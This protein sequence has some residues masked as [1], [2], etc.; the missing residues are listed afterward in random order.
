MP[1]FLIPFISSIRMP[2]SILNLTFPRGRETGLRRIL[3]SMVLML[4][5]FP[6][7][8]P[9]GSAILILTVSFNCCAAWLRVEMKHHKLAISKSVVWRILKVTL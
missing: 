7:H 5:P 9:S 3:C 2:C 6:S 1:T 4:P 8:L